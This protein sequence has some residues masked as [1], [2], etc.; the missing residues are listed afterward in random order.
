MFVNGSG[1]N[2]Q[3]LQSFSS[4]GWGVSE[5]K[6]KMWKVNGQTADA[7]WWQKLAL[8]LARWAKYCVKLDVP[9][10]TCIQCLVVWSMNVENETY[11]IWK[12]LSYSPNIFKRYTIDDFR[13][14]EYK[15]WSI[16]VFT[17]IESH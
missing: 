14:G 3:S 1:R 9:K 5:E 10:T 16:L 6:I 2:E 12:K 8:P 15:G 13:W 7:K 11:H 17:E 4:F